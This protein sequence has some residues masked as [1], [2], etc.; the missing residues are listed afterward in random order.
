MAVQILSLT[1]PTRVPACTTISYL[2]CVV[3]GVCVM[4]QYLTVEA[5]EEARERLRS[6]PLDELRLG[7]LEEE[8]RVMAIL[9]AADKPEVRYTDLT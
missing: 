1:R 3:C 5:A 4:D 2:L 6:L 9:V 8:L 7:Q